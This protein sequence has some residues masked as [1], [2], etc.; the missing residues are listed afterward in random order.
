MI[1]QLQEYL[2]QENNGPP[3][4]PLSAEHKF[5]SVKQWMTRQ[6]PMFQLPNSHPMRRCSVRKVRC[7]TFCSH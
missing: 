5:P 7:F 3:G 1:H 4:E 6:H 2:G